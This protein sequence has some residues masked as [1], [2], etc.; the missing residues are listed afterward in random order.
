MKVKYWLLFLFA[1]SF[2]TLA[3]SSPSTMLQTT[4]DEVIAALKSNQA[5]LKN[6][7]KVAYRII[8]TII[9]PRFD[10]EG[11]ARSVLPRN[12]WIQATAGQRAQFTQQ[13]TN[14]LVRTYA[15]ALASY[16]NETVQY[17]PP[18]GNAN[19]SRMQINS[20]ILRQ[21]GPSI[22]VSYRLVFIGQ[23]WKIYDFAV[24]GISMLQSYRSQFTD[25]LSQGGNINTVIQKLSQ[26][27][28]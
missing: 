20:T 26:H 2:C 12:I 25:Q 5:T 23:N 18:R 14:L 3:A 4:T 27:N 9:V 6:N 24:D 1:F 15:S 17:L 10:L 28:A 7:P 22:S 19:N 16:Q 21:G 11:M 13:F 8:N